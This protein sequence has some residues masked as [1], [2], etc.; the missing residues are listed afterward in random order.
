MSDPAVPVDLGQLVEEETKAMQLVLASE[1]RHASL[2]IAFVE[3]DGLVISGKAYSTEMDRGALRG[4]LQLLD[5]QR[6]QLA[7][8]LD[9]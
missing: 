4:M 3:R 8:L 5:H 1:G 6:A 9:G 7:G 2:V